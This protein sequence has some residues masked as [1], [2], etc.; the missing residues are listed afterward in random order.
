MQDH[1]LDTLPSGTAC[2]STLPAIA[3]GMASGSPRPMREPPAARDREDVMLGCLDIP[4]LAR[5]LDDMRKVIG[6]PIALVD[7]DDRVRVTAPWQRLCGGFLRA[8]ADTSG[9]CAAHDKAVTRRL[10]AGEETISAPCPHGLMVCATRIVIDDQHVATLKVGQ[11]RLGSEDPAP[12]D[13]LR[14]HHGFADTA[15]QEAV[16]EVPVVDPARLPG[17]LALMRS[18]ARQ[19]AAHTRAEARA[20]EAAARAEALLAD[21]SAT[22]RDL[23]YRLTRIAEQVPGAIF[24]YRLF[25]DGTSCFPYAS[26]GLRDIYGLSPGDVRTDASPVL[27]AIHPDDAAWL[28]D[29]IRRSAQT[30]SV[31]HGQ[32]RARHPVKGTIWLEGRATPERL[33]DGSVLWHG[34]IVDVTDRVETERCLRDT[35]D[36]YRLVT[37]AVRDGTWEFDLRTGQCSVDDRFQALLGIPPGQHELSVDAW[38]S[39]VHPNDVRPLRKGLRAQWM[40][41]ETMQV[42]YRHRGADGDWLWVEVRGRVLER[43]CGWPVHVVGTIR[44]ISYRK[45]IEAALQDSEARF[46]GLFEHAPIAYVALDAAGRVVDLN[47]PLCQMLGRSRADILGQ[48]FGAFLAPQTRSAGTQ[49]L[50]RVLHDDRAHTDLELQPTHGTV[51]T[52]QMVSQVQRDDE[53]AFLR[54]HCVL[55]DITA[56]AHLE[57]RLAR[58]NADLSQF[59]YAVS[60]DLREPLRM[61]SGFLGLIE[62]RMGP[63]IDPELSEFLGFAIDG[64]RRLDRMILDLLDYSR[65]GRDGDEAVP[66]GLSD[67]IAEALVNVS[68]A[69]TDR[70]AR[71]DVAA[72]LPTIRGRRPDLVRLFQ[73]VIGNAIKFV[74]ADRTPEVTVR[75]RE[76]SPVLWRIT[77]MD[78]G[79]GIPMDMRDRVFGVFERLVREDEVAGTGIGLALCRK[80]VERHGGEIWFADPLDDATA[81]DARGGAV[82]HL[83][84]PK[85]S[86][87]GAGPAL[88]DPL[89]RVTLL[90]TLNTHQVRIAARLKNLSDTI[91]HRHGDEA[92]VRGELDFLVSEVERYRVFVHANAET[93]YGYGLSRDDQDPRADADSLVFSVHQV[94]RTMEDNDLATAA[95]QKT[96]AQTL[97]TLLRHLRR[98]HAWLQRRRAERLLERRPSVSASPERPIALHPARP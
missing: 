20:R 34:L 78:N 92:T 25:P 94:H 31:W 59:A 82:L 68:A 21:R 29:S 6:L 53:G 74:P 11:F 24:Q 56:H 41:G 45:T 52:V 38:L 44:D 65:V 7:R 60:H 12:L 64:A 49:R 35:Q 62:H 75:C 91:H 84:L 80:I 40:A 61:V 48:V 19:I 26:E 36:R 97:N 46:R 47:L 98:S 70:A 22:V 67:V 87:D 66:V 51:L 76:A 32:Y 73:N 37:Q 30:D 33:S 79:M 23:Q 54:S 13:A 58:S 55:H 17:I 1:P 90:E 2:S 43:D 16:A 9:A 57:A 27:A 5:L 15:F 88:V 81:G 95:G 63:A 10:E 39:A 4:G 86:A 42:E 89:D 77:V 93:I 85:Q 18:L 28:R 71:I 8:H 96:I 3:L 69:I 83:T 14:H 72:S 50:A